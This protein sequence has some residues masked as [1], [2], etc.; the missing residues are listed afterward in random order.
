MFIHKTKATFLQSARQFQLPP[1]TVSTTST[2]SL[3]QNLAASIA[4][5]NA[6]IMVLM[7]GFEVRGHVP[8][9]HFPKWP[10]AKPATAPINA[11]I[12]IFISFFSQNTY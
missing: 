2:L 7:I 12:I 4:P 8:E 1:R 5:N 9:A 3:C 6:P 11:P 10:T